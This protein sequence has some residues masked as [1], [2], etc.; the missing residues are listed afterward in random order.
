[1]YTLLIKKKNREKNRQQLPP[2][3]LKYLQSILL[4]FTMPGG[5]EGI[6]T[7]VSKRYYMPRR[8]QLYLAEAS[9]AAALTATQKRFGLSTSLNSLVSAV[10]VFSS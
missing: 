8:S 2:Q 10:V 6:G 9:I 1:L 5:G 3:V 7:Q 4:P